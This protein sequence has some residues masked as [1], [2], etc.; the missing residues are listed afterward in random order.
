MSKVSISGNASGTGVFTIQAPSSNTDR[1]LS[2]PDEAGTVLTTAGVPASA[3]PA[4]SVIQVIQSQTAGAVATSSTSFVTSGL[5]AS[6]TPTST[7]NKVLVLLN[8]GGQYGGT[9]GIKNNQTTIY[10]GGV[11]LGSGS[12]ISLERLYLNDGTETAVPHS[13]SILDSPNTTSST[14]YT[15]YFKAANG[16]AIYFNV[17]GD[18]GVVTLTLMEIAG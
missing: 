11:N 17:G 1:V 5:S 14:T 13:A 6:I 7:S 16:N 2:L 4:G 12:E 8:G 9:S 15:A 10:R 3:M 18:S